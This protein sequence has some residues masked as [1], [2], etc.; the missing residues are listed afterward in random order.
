MKSLNFKK[1][2]L[3]MLKKGDKIA[4]LR[5]GKKNYRENEMVKIIAGNEFVGIA[6]IIKV[7]NIKWNELKKEDAEIEGMKSKN[8]LKKELK[9]IYGKVKNDD[10]FT[11]IIFEIMG[12][13][14]GG[15]KKI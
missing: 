13:E 6:K 10:E 3:E 8:E 7:R 12:D 9:E 4:T 11:Q 15:N 14:N 5:L 1:K 2:Y